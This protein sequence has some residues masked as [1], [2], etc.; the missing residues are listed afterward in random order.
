VPPRFF[1]HHSLHEVW[2]FVAH[3]ADLIDLLGRRSYSFASGA[4]PRKGLAIGLLV[5]LLK[6]PCNPGGIFGPNVDFLVSV[7][8]GSLLFLLEQFLR[9]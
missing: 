9:R 5:G 2:L 3:F 8:V 4:L 7:I 1:S 6:L